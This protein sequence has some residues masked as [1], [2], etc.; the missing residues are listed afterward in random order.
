M[1]LNRYGQPIGESLLHRD[2]PPYPNAVAM[3]GNWC[4]LEPI[5]AN[6]HADAL[7]DA[8]AEAPDDRGWT[9]LSWGPFADRDTF[10]AWVDEMSEEFY[11]PFW[12]VVVDDKA[13]GFGCYLA[14]SP[15]HFSLEIGH[16]HFAPRLWRTPAAT[17]ALHLWIE[18][19]F[20]LGYRRVEWKCDVLNAPSRSAARRLGFSFEGIFRNHRRFRG[21]N[22]D[23]AWYAIV[24]EDW[25]A[26]NAI[27]RTWLDPANFDEAGT[28]RFRLSERTS[29]LRHPDPVDR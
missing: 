26:L 1:P 21:H 7:W 3:L 11:S 23:T 5:D 24:E 9:Y 6:R 2:Q 22:R 25:P 8:F 4:R 14:I 29:G 28:Q 16:L 18:H 10:R 27:H 13:C 19:A 17:E 12:A 15:T 20:T